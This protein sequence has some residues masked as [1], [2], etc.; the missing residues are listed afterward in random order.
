LLALPIKVLLDTSILL[1]SLELPFDLLG[2]TERLLKAKVEFLIPQQVE[3]ELQRLSKKQTSVGIRAARALEMAKKCKR[4]RVDSVTE[5]KADDALI[6][7][8]RETKA[9]VATADSQLRIRLRSLNVP[10]LSLRGNRL[11]CEPETP[12][13]WPSML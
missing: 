4:L 12:E 9:I 5:T 2:E 3:D 8:S 10:V 11:Y 7:A 1:T 13:Y 6:M